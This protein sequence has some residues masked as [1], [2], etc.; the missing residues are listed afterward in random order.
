MPNQTYFDAIAFDKELGGARGIDA[1]LKAHDLDA[2]LLLSQ[3]ASGPAAI[4]GYPVV[5]GEQVLSA[6]CI[7]YHLIPSSPSRFLRSEHYSLSRD[8]ASMTRPGLTFR[9]RAKIPMQSPH[10]LL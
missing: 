5:T 10:G 6:G 3:S 2:L 1:A 9:N 7:I 8:P 4:V